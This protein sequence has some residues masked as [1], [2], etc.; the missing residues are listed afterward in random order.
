MTYGESKTLKLNISLFDNN[1]HQDLQ[2]SVNK[3]DVLVEFSTDHSPLLFSPDLPKVENRGK[4]LWKFN[5]SL[6]INSD[7]ATKMKHCIKSTIQTL[8][9][10]GIANFQAR[11]E[12]LK[13]KIRNF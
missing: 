9:K 3:T 13:Y 8:E 5:N 4:G 10:V 6:S 11:W 7:F 12:F 2:E 1:I